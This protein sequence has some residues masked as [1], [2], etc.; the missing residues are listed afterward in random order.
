VRSFLRA[1]QLPPILL[2]GAK[3]ENHLKLPIVKA[4]KRFLTPKK[5]FSTCKTAKNRV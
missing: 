4:K 3:V 5:L 2:P 1:A